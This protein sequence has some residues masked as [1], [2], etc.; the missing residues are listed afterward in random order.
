MKKSVLIIGG[1]ASGIFAAIISARRGLQVILIEQ[2]E[3]IGKKL[4]ATGNG[5]CN[6][7]N[8]FMEP[9]CYRS[10][11][12]EKAFQV[13]ETFGAKETLTF[14]SELGLICR[15]KDGYYYPRTMQASSVL[16]VLR[17]ELER[18]GVSIVTETKATS[19][20]YTDKM[21][22]VHTT[23]KTF[24]VQ[25]VILAAGAKASEALGSDGSGYHFTQTFG[26]SLVTPVPA[27]VPLIGKGEYFK[28]LK[29]I[30]TQA[31]VHAM[32]DGKEVAVDTG[33][34]QWTQYGISGIPIFQISRFLSYA[35]IQNK[36]AEVEIDFLPELEERE[37]LDI[38][39][40]CHLKFTEEKVDSFFT[41]I[42]HKRIGETILKQ[43][44]IASSRCIKSLTVTELKKLVNDCKRFKVTIIDTK[45]FGQA[46]VCAGGVPLH[47]VQ[48][49][50]MESKLV[51][52][53]YL[54][55]EILD[56]DGI[57]GGYNLQWAWATG[58]LAGKHVLK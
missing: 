35:L 13:I 41:G 8:A 56:V 6:L 28:H 24:S 47:E 45:G 10:T 5:R 18:L 23:Q 21:F 33:E 29:G 3:K 44:G 20:A 42:F 7:T 43:S 36:K 40:K 11:D 51:K 39:Q 55:G 19:I 52:N 9:S 25:A 32:V 22:K 49:C 17:M 14:F 2:K 1:G 16:D 12:L 15:A 31:T 26:H 46:Q 58:Y 54:T 50:T 37:I 48:L 27:L 53:L 4:L 57:C 38:F 30:R 34:M